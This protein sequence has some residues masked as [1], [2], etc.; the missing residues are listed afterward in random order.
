M[1]CDTIL[2]DPDTWDLVVDSSGN[3]ASAVPPYALAQDVAS[4]V[5][6]FIK[7]LWYEKNK[8]IPYFEQVLGKTPP[9]SLLKRYI[10]NAA[11]AVPGVVSAKCNIT[12]QNREVHGQVE[13]VDETG[14][15]STVSI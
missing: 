14:K 3:I 11:L 4:A 2:L 13:F 10:V 12:N 1:R 15:Q 8:G 5:R 9:L 7:E 6:L